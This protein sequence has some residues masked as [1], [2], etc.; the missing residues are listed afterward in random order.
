MPHMRVYLNYCVNQANAGKVLQ[1]L[2]DANPELSARL[3]C[4][5][6][7]SSARNLDLS[8]CLLVPMQRLT[9]YPLLIRQI[10]QYTD[11]PTPTPDLFV[12][13]RLTLSLPT[14]HAERESIANSLAC[15]ERILEEVNE[16]VRDREGRERLVR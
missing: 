1:S 4:L 14:E 6:E 9:R 16:T 10:L 5:R 2:R 15:A 3:Q 11:P 12:A 8:S 13:P 7:D